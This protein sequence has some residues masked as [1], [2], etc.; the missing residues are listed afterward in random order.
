MTDKAIY[1]FDP[2]AVTLKK[3][4][5][6]GEIEK[7][8]AMAAFSS[9]IYSLDAESGKI[10][11][12]VKVS[13]GYGKRSEYIADGS[14]VKGATSIAI[15]SNMY[16]LGSDGKVAKYLSGKKQDFTIEEM[17]FDLQKSGVVFTT[18]DVEGLYLT[19]GGRNVVIK[20]DAKG[21]Y[22]ASYT[23]DNFANLN[24]IFVDDASKTGYVS[25]SGKIYKL[26][27]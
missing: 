9:N 5:A 4:D 23:S 24:G 18:E 10:Y 21:K 3:Q 1:E 11:K 20:V 2:T 15:D 27:F 12:R 25:A 22:V 14:D 6:A 17:P 16:A 13:G 26:S 8:T 19:D 7:A